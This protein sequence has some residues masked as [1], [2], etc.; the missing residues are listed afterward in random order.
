MKEDRYS[1]SYNAK[2]RMFS[3]YRNERKFRVFPA[4]KDAWEFVME[5]QEEARRGL[6]K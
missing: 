1:V 4:E 6:G 5:K 3:V 2:K